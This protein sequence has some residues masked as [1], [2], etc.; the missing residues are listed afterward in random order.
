MD[1]DAAGVVMTVEEP[2]RPRHRL[3]RGALVVLLVLALAVAGAFVYTS[4]TK[5]NGPIFIARYL[6]TR[7]SDAG[8]LFAHRSIAASTTPRSLD[9]RLTPLPESVPWKGADVSTEKVLEETH[10]NSLMVV[11]RGTVVH[12][13][14]ATD[15]DRTRRQSSWS[16]AKSVV[17]LLIGQLIG[18]GRLF[19]DTRLVEVLPEFATGTDFDTITVGD[20]LDMESGIDVAE[21]YSILKPFTGVGGMEMTTDL[22][23]YLKKNRGLRFEPGSRSQYR[24]VDAQ[25]LSMIVS[26]IEGE[27]LAAVVERKLWGP[28][29]AEDGATWSLDREGGIEKGFAALNATPRDF[30]KIGQLVLDGGKVDGRQIVPADWITR[31][32][33]PVV[34]ADPGWMYAAQW[35]HPPGYEANRDFSAIGVYGQF[36]YVNP[37]HQSVVVKLSDHGAEQDEADL[38]EVFRSFADAC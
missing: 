13:W 8:T 29:G 1:D 23:G 32:S 6:S 34:E 16:V 10:S 24:S 20:L 22:V 31:I 12:E 19:E 27:S 15:D 28:M 17:S 21:D 18:E 14:Y 2:R 5:M 9:E 30:A 35:W 33:T 3:R 11:C 25:Y 7:S 37:E 4:A 38:V 26:R 36:I